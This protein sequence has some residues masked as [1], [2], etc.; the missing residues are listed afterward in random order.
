MRAPAP[1]P[2]ER[3]SG[4][5]GLAPPTLSPIAGTA[6]SAGPAAL[7]QDDAKITARSFSFCGPPPSRQGMRGGRRAVPL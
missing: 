4:W 5:R 7:G 3:G 6:G 2:G 1:H